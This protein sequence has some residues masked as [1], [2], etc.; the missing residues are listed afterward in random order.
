MSINTEVAR[1]EGSMINLDYKVRGCY[2]EKYFNERMLLPSKTPDLDSGQSL[3]D[4]IEETQMYVK[5]EI[6]KL[7]NKLKR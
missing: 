5:A 4:L 1:V 3:I 2:T 7:K 6:R